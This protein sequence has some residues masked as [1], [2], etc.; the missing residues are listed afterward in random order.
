MSQGSNNDDAF[1][2]C[3]TYSTALEEPALHERIVKLARSR[4]YSAVRC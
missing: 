4:S 1:R 3:G 2:Q